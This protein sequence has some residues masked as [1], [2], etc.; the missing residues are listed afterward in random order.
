VK[1]ASEPLRVQVNHIR[2]GI[3][4]VILTVERIFSCAGG[5]PI[6]IE[7]TPEWVWVLGV[8]LAVL[9]TNRRKTEADQ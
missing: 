2:I 6:T 1:A 7:P 4:C 9:T 5:I 8:V 3:F